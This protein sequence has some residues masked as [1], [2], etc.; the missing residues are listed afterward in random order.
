MDL[1]TRT[2]KYKHINSFIYLRSVNPYKVSQ[3]IRYRTCHNI[4]V[5]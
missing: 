3:P 2:E 1:Y 4:K 5:S